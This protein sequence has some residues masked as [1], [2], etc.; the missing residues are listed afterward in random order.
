MVRELER[1][2]QGVTFPETS[3]AANPVFFRTYSRRTAAGLRESWDEVC[4]RTIQGLIEL[5]KLN[6]EEIALLE[7]TQHQLK[8]LPRGLW[9]WV[10]GTDWINKP[11]NFSGGYNCTSTNLQDWK[12]F[13]LMMDLAMMGC[14]TGDIIEPQYQKINAD[15]VVAIPDQHSNIS[16]KSTSLNLEARDYMLPNHRGSEDENLTTSNNCITNSSAVELSI[17]QERL[18]QVKY[19]SKQQRKFF[20]WLRQKC[21]FW[22]PIL[23]VTVA[24]ASL[25]R[26]LFF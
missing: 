16:P 21:R 11:K 17:A 14:G 8:A 7:K 13:G 22:H 2:R 23:G 25:I 24:I 9:L 20:W 10:G 3:P 18:Q 15:L 5:G 19:R 12:A 4:D 6:P 1:K 26:L